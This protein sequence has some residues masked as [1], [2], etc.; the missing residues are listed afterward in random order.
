MTELEISTLKFHGPLVDVR[1]DGVRIDVVSEQQARRILL[2][3]HHEPVGCRTVKYLRL[4]PGSPGA[5][6]FKRTVKNGNAG[7]V[8]QVDWE[9]FFGVHGKALNGGL[10]SPR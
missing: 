7:R 10:A 8:S 6:K 3:G 4:L 5:S 1:E 2:I 9:Q